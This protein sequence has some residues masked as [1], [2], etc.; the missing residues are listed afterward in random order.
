MF[1]KKVV[2]LLMLFALFFSQLPLGSLAAEPTVLRDEFSQVYTNTNLSQTIEV[3]PYSLFTQNTDT[4]SW[5]KKEN[6]DI[7]SGAISYVSQSE[8][9]ANFHQENEVKVGINATQQYE[10]YIKFGDSLPSLNGGLYLGATLR[11]KE[12]NNDYDC[13]SCEYYSNEEFSIHKIVEPWN[14]QQLT[15]AN[16]PNALNTPISNKTLVMPVG[17]GTYTWDVSTLVLDWMKNPESDYGLA[18]KPSENQ[19]EQ[20]VLNFTKLNNNDLNQMPVLQIQFSSKPNAPTGISYGLQTN[21]GKGL[22]NLQWSSVTGA[23]G[24]RVYLYNGKEYE[25]VYEGT[26]TKWSSLGKNIWPTK[27]QMNNGEL[28]LRADGS[29]TD[30]SDIPGFL[31]QLHGNS[32]KAADTYYFR[33]SAFNDYGETD[34]S[35]VTAVKMP[36]TSA[37][38]VPEN[39]KASSELISNF[40]IFWDPSVDQSPVE[41]QVKLTTDSGYE[42]FT[43]ATQ[44]NSITIP[45]HYLTPRSNYFVSVKA[46]DKNNVQ[47]NFSSYS[48]NVPVT[49]RKKNDAELVGMSYPSSIQE[50]GSSPTIKVVFKNT[51]TESWTQ[52]GGYLLKADHYSVGLAPSEIVETGETQTFELKLPADMPLGTTPIIWRMFNQNSGFF[53]NQ[54]SMAISLEDRRNPQISL[55]SPVPYQRVSGKVTLEGAI[56]DYQL[57]AYTISYGYGETPTEWI[58]IKKSDILS[59]KFGEW[60]TTNIKNGTYTL[61]IEAEDTSGGKSTLERIVTVQNAVPI[62]TVQEVTDQSTEITGSAKLGTTVIVFEDETIISNGPVSEDGTFSLALPAQAPGTELTLIAMDGQVASDAARVTVKDIT[63]PEQP[64]VNTVTNKTK[65]ISGKTEPYATVQAKL[66]DKTYSSIADANGYFSIPVPV[67][68]YGT[69]IVMTVQ[70]SAKL[71]S[72]DKRINVTRVAPNVPTVNLVHNKATLVSG[73]TEKYATV[74]VVNGTRSYTAKADAY[75]VYKITIP[76]QNSGTVLSV[77]AKDSLGASSM[78]RSVSVARVAPNIP[79]V[80]PVYNNTSYISGQTEKLALVTVSI[81]SKTYNVRADAYG[82]FKMTIPVQNSGVKLTVTAKDTAGKISSPTTI[83]VGRAAPNMPTA[84]TVR[85]YSTTVTGKT[86]QS[87]LVSVKIGSRT[88]S[89]KSDY[90]GN[91]R[92]YI[93]KQRK[94]NVLTVLTKDARGK[95]SAARKIT[96]Y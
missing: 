27:E 75:G 10:T 8:P 70:D 26:D 79:R 13:Y 71:T 48:S 47:S 58:P 12:L 50:A 3:S 54:S 77:T 81:G 33:I 44:S 39:I 60:N 16:K 45:E 17:G 68:N 37:P 11:L 36:D 41:Y 51:G 38:T 4:L 55:V 5:S 43:G 14:A 2:L 29:G 40:T 63:P 22:V 64:I 56:L 25:Q 84:N 88:Y 21:S 62:P 96:V 67:Q 24:Y 7:Q 92:V 49:T 80:N 73:K 42:V 66:S 19:N 72:I 65:A 93:P 74:T 20:H 6:I 30:L 57:K 94:G 9:D 28:T 78:P 18:I 76:V 52:S 82:K 53:G 87:V 31:Y 95:L 91:Y 61:R 69:P 35:E 89:A 23:K 1:I 83:T 34:L 46:I 86:E 90:Y 15:W 59:V 85:Y 32:E